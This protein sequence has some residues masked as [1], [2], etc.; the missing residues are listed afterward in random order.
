M[1]SPASRH[2]THFVPFF[3]ELILST[4]ISFDIKRGQIFAWAGIR[5]QVSENIYLF[6]RDQDLCY[7]I[8]VLLVHLKICI[9]IKKLKLKLWLTA[10]KGT[11]Q[12]N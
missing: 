9:Y 11:I 12:V 8:L 6:Q 7:Y 10:P 1:S 5:S 4:M 2:Y 3:A